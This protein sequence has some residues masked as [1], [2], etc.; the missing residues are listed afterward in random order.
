ML[1]AQQPCPHLEV[2]CVNPYEL[3]RKYKCGACGEVIMCSCDRE[4]GE[5]FL[6][7]QLDRAQDQNTGLPVPVT[8]GFQDRICRECRGLTAE[9]HPKDE[10]YGRSSKIV[11]YYWREIFFETTRRFA[12]WADQVGLDRSRARFEHP[13]KYDAIERI[14]IEEFKTLHAASPKYEYTEASAADVLLRCKVEIVDLRARYILGEDGT[15]MLVTPSGS[16]KTPEQ[17]T[18]SHYASLGFESLRCESRPFHVLFGIYMWPVIQDPMDEL[19]H[20]VEFGNRSAFEAGQP[21]EPVVMSLPSDFGKPDFAERRAGALNAHFELLA[22]DL[23]L[24]F[25]LWLQPSANLRQYLWAHR[26]EDVERARKLVEVLPAD[27]IRRVLRYLSGSYWQRYLGWPDLFLFNSDS[28]LFVEVKGSGDKL[29]EDQK[30]W[31]QDNAET[32][33]LPFK[34]VKIHREHD[35]G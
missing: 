14:A 8:G 16:F 31:I 7:H 6:P 21:A 4:F 18:E 9:A 35:P 29:S 17:L 20:H 32:L 27:V 1:T 30:R 22:D 12:A 5:E 15:R 28:Y 33:K 3:I 25:D 34:L 11:R 23:K 26:E 24:F 2:T 19:Q 13:A 10:L